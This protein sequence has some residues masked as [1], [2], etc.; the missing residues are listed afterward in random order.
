[1]FSRGTVD[2]TDS[3]SPETIVKF[4]DC[5]KDKKEDELRN[6]F[7]DPT[8]KVWLLKE[9]NDYT[10]LH[11]AVFMDDLKITTLIIEELKKRLGFESKTALS[12]FINE[13]TN[14]G[15]TALHYAAYKGNIDIAK[16]LIS[17][18]AHIQ[19]TTNRG[20][21]VMHLAAEGNQPTIMMYFIFHE[22]QDIHSIDEF[23]STP[24][25]WACYAGAEDSVLFLLSMKVDIDRTDKEGLTPLHVATTS[26]KDKIVLRLLQKGADKTIKNNKQETP[27]T[28]ATTKNF[29]KIKYL[30]EDKDY[31]PLCTL[32]T[33]IEYVQPSDLYKKLIAF[34]MLIPELI[35]LLFVL[36]YV[37]GYI[38]VW[39][40]LGLVFFAY[41]SYFCLVLKGP[42][43]VKDETLLR[44]AKNDNPL[45]IL[46][47]KHKSLNIFCPT[48]YVQ[49]RSKV[50]HC[51]I[52]DKCVD[53]F[54]H[55]C[56]WLNTCIGKG[57]VFPYFCFLFF[58]FLYAMFNI[59]CCAMCFRSQ[60]NWTDKVQ[61][62]KTL[63]YFAENNRSTRILASALVFIISAV[64]SC[65]LMFLF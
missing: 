23:G 58:N 65:P 45:K 5:V 13:Q 8:I 51:F 16:L 9:E 33:P 25:H 30:L 2:N 7:R 26:N 21:N 50:K 43:F 24:L 40:N 52:C 18:G 6:Y 27:L 19:T 32:Q 14:E 3:I 59:Y 44:E 42:G 61:F 4:F 39:I 57:N 15:L 35:L 49:K 56:F 62:W 46:L 38:E 29:Y 22:A 41:L 20:K 17:N 63:A 36:P 28:I 31:N 48:C 53:G 12:K 11:R 60:L 54:Y 55:H 1:M 34:F 37:Q 47:E 64:F 10:A